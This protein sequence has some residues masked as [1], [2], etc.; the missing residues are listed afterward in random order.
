MLLNMITTRN[1]TLKPMCSSQ[2]WRKKHLSPVPR[3]LA[4][5][6]TT[7]SETTGDWGRAELQCCPCSFNVPRVESCWVVRQ[8]S[9]EKGRIAGMQA[10]TSDGIQMYIFYAHI[11]IVCSR[12]TYTFT[13]IYIYIY[14][15]IYIPIYFVYAWMQLKKLEM[16]CLQMHL[17]IYMH[18]HMQMFLHLH[19]HI[20]VPAKFYMI[21]RIYV[22]CM[23]TWFL[24]TLRNGL[25]LFE[26]SR[27]CQG[28]LEG[29]SD[30]ASYSFFGAA[31][32]TSDAP[33]QG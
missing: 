19:I 32:F 7:L 1:L 15:H 28:I 8:A 2:K 31:G 5:K 29:L 9:L 27:R 13:I 23:V 12:L 3:T 24:V 30:K 25:S 17:H 21:Y 6:F 26:L 16:F 11:F 33:E 14:I 10:L 22:W 4:S 18:N 20:H